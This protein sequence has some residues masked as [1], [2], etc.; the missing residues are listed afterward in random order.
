M[1]NP[2]EES[3]KDSFEQELEKIKSNTVLSEDYRRKK[4]VLWSVRT[5]LAILLYAVFW[6]YTWVRWS[7]IAYIPLNLLG[8]FSIYGVRY[9]LNKKI[10]Q[11][12]ERIEGM[13]KPADHEET[14]PD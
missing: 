2:E 4:F 10:A 14:H 1:S 13:E 12:R 6:K 9:L 8:L 7:L 11:T 5:I 3:L